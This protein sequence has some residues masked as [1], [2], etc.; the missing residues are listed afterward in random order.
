MDDTLM[1]T[2]PKNLSAMAADDKANERCTGGY[3]RVF[4]KSEQDAI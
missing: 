3:W 4:N 2:G 1:G